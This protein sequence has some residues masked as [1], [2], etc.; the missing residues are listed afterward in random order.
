MVSS[1]PSAVDSAAAGPPAATRPDTTYGRPA[2]SGVAST[3]RSPPITISASCTMP[4]P[5]MSTILSNPGST[6]AHADAQGGSDAKL[7]PTR[8][9]YISYFASTARQGAVK[10]SMKMHTSDQ[11][12]E[13]RA[14]CTLGVV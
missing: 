2:I 3:I 11:N 4:S 13:V 1:N 10:Y 14:S 5:L 8:F 12:T 7:L 9:V 6:F